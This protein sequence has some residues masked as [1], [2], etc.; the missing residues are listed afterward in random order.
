MKAPIE[1]NS[2]DVGNHIDQKVSINLNISEHVDSGTKLDFI[3][4]IMIPHTIS[5]GKTCT[6]YTTVVFVPIF[7]N[8]EVYSTNEG[9]YLAIDHDQD[10]KLDSN[11]SVTVI[12]HVRKEEKSNRYAIEVSKIM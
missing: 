9:V 7:E 3:M 11:R 4:P 6:T 5:T 12:G 8:Y 2:S 1:I 10:V